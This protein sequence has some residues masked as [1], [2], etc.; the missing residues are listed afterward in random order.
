MLT[1]ETILKKQFPKARVNFATGVFAINSV[2]G[3]DSL[4]H[5]NLLLLIE[6]EF[7]IQFTDEEMAEIKNTS[8]IREALGKHGIQC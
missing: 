8:Q 1:L 3:W 6:N 5:F 7:G 2:E 4:G